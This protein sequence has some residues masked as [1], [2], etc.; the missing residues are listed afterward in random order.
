MYK[1][2]NE[3]QICNTATND[4]TELQ[5]LDLGQAQPYRIWPG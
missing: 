1:N 2:I 5:A 3:K 4:T